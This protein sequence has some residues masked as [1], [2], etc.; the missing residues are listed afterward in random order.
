MLIGTIKE[1][2]FNDNYYIYLNN[3]GSYN[4]LSIIHVNNDVIESLSKEKAKSLLN[5]LLS[6]KLAFSE[7]LGDYEIYLDE[8]SNK[9]YFKNGIEDYFLF[10]AKN[11]I[12]DV[13][14]LTKKSKKNN[15]SKS[16]TK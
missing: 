5:T 9:R 4:E 14:L 3:K 13:K 6:S 2:K 11:G 7:K 16:Y 15:Y 1:K 12:D 8:A 10:F